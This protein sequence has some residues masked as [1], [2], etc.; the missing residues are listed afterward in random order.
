VSI[1]AISSIVAD[2]KRDDPKI[3]VIAYPHW[4]RNYRWASKTQRRNAHAMIDS[5]VDLIIGHGAHLIQEVE[6]YKGHWIAYS[7]GNFVFGSPGRYEKKHA[8]PYGAI[9]VL[10]LSPDGDGVAERLRLYPTFTN[11]LVTNYQSRFV[12]EAEFGEVRTLLR[13]HSESA[14][15]FDKIVHPGADEY[16]FFLDLSGDP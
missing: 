4:G 7:L 11:N 5:G 8:H 2:L 16:G 14:D 9:G 6:R 3:F 12:T 10:Q 1:P 15:R 13:A